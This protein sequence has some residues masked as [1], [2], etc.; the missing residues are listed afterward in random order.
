MHKEAVVTAKFEDTLRTLVISGRPL[1][2]R[3][4][5]YIQEW[6]N[7]PADIKRLTEVEGIVPM[8]KDL[9]NDVD[10]DIPF[11]MGQ[12]AGVINEVK[13]AREIVEELVSD[14]VDMLRKGHEYTTVQSKL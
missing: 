10:V 11:L 12:V 5:D 13:P 7:R 2:V 1:R 6:E 8:Q 3:M 4:N 9:D 14:A